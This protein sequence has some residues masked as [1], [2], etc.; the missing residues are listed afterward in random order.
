MRGPSKAADQGRRHLAA[1]VLLLTRLGGHLVSADVASWAWPRG[2][3]RTQ[4]SPTGPGVAPAPWSS[5]RRRAERDERVGTDEAADRGVITQVSPAEDHADQAQPPRVLAA[6]PGGDV[7]GL[8]IGEEPVLRDERL[9]PEPHPGCRPGAQLRTQ[10][11][12]GPQAAQMTASR[13]SASYRSTIATVSYGRPVLRPVWVNSKNV[14]PSSHPA[15]C[16]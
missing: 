14:R 9:A 6:E 8:V 2:T 5:I 4:A 15:S 11:V 7:E 13:A 10:S 12:P 1:A 3:G 16:R